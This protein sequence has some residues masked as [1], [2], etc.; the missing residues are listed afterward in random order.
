[1]AR[2]TSVDAKRQNAKAGDSDGTRARARVRG[3]RNAFISG[4]PA[5]RALD[6]RRR[7]PLCLCTRERFFFLHKTRVFYWAF[8]PLLLRARASIVISCAHILL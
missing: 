4:A 6:P 5:L 1:M 8:S 3:R 7:A 2:Q